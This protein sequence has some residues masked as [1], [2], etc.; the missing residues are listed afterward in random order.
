MRTFSKAEFG[1]STTDGETRP[2]K[3]VGA[4]LLWE[5]SMLSNKAEH[6]G[7]AVS[8]ET[9]ERSE[10]GSGGAKP[11]KPFASGQPHV[12]MYVGE[13]MRTR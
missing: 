12:Q 13:R 5:E 1:K 6:Q 7:A 11:W 3:D 4:S 9:M 8:M 10:R 2:S